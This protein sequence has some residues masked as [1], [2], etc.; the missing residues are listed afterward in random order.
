[1]R[2]YT[3]CA[4]CAQL[5]E[6]DHAEIVRDYHRDCGPPELTKPRLVRH[7]LHAAIVGQISPEVIAHTLDVI[8]HGRPQYL[9]AALA[10]ARWGWPVFPCVPGRKTPLTEHGLHEASAEPEQIRAWW[11]R[12]PRGNIGLPTGL[13]F[14]VVDIDPAGLPWLARLR[15][16]PGPT[17]PAS[18]AQA[19]TPRA[20]LHLYLPASGDGNLAG[21]ASGVDYRGAG[22]YV[23][24]P[25]STLGPAAYLDKEPPDRPQPWRYF[26]AVYP[27][28]VITGGGVS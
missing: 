3:A 5:L 1:M 2:A 13:A 6:V 7:F 16:T 24:A 17:L 14:D 18:H 21:L 11:Q 19:F 27:S 4:T 26:W 10:Y 22:G 8:D 23:L 15:Q 12:W 28:P 25:P 9:A 20:G